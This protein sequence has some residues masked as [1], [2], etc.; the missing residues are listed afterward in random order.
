MVVPHVVAHE[1]FA[2]WLELVVA[3][4]S[5]QAVGVTT[6]VAALSGF[7]ML[8]RQTTWVTTNPAGPPSY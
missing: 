2:L 8:Q 5:E 1:D 7:G 6:R 4:V 3:A